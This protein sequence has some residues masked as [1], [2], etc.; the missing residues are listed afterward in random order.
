MSCKK[1]FCVAQDLNA[2]SYLFDWSKKRCGCCIDI[3]SLMMMMMMMITQ[4]PALEQRASVQDMMEDL[5]WAKACH[6]RRHQ[7]WS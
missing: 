1:N 5:N 7:C 4:G 3:C 6:H 2:S